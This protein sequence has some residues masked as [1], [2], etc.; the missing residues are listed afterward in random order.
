M[1]KIF[2][3][4][5]ICIF[6][7]VIQLCAF[8]TNQSADVVVGQSSMTGNS[9]NQGGGIN[10]GTLSGPSGVA[11]NGNRLFITDSGNARSLIYNPIPVLNN[12]AAGIVIGQ[13]S[14]TSAVGVLSSSGCSDPTGIFNIG[15]QIFYID[16]MYNR[17]LIYNQIP[18]TNGAPADRVVGQA[19]MFSSVAACTANNYRN[20]L[21]ICSDG[22]RLFVNDQHNNR[23][24]IYS[25]IPT[26]DNAPANFVVGQSNMTGSLPNQGSA[27]SA[28]TL[29]LPNGIYASGGRLFIGDGAN[30]RVL[31][32][33]SIPTSNNAAANIV[34]GQSNMT[35][36]SV[37]QGNASPGANTLSGP[38]DVLYDG[39]RLFI[40]DTG[41]NRVL[42]YNSLPNTHNASANVVL[43]QADMTSKTAGCTDHNFNLP[44]A[45]AKD[46]TSFYVADRF[47]HRVMVFYDVVKVF[48]VSPAQGITG[49]QI[50]ASLT[51][52]KFGLDMTVKLSN[53]SV[54]LI[55]T[56]IN[57]INLTS[58]T[59]SFNLNTSP[60]TFD[61]KVERPGFSPAILS[62]AFTIL[63]VPA[64][65]PTPAPINDTSSMP[66]DFEGQII[67]KNYC[68]AAPN[69]IRG[70]I[71]KIHVI[72]KQAATVK[73]KIFT[74]LGSDGS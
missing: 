43:G 58:A 3:W 45:F 26:T 56:S 21:Q 30:N 47:N 14:M 65:T 48:S 2:F 49:T 55:G 46:E 69:P 57:V 38:G 37:N 39:T 6:I 24:L 70:H 54:D 72:C 74:P 25:S 1:Q 22:T 63:P 8:T 11:V 67:S 51:G 19:D 52:F 36:N 40:L 61:V 13:P 32:F 31:I 59:C 16:W 42:I 50:S 27:V 5:F 12:T 28:S 44:V 9:A 33:N 53:G 18:I 35:S 7:P 60:G 4:L 73:I 15:S 66:G 41:N 62:N 29:N 34:V 23:V 68:Y 71:A 64:S 17:A 20:P 10:A